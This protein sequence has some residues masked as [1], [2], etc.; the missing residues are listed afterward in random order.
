LVLWTGPLNTK[1]QR[2]GQLDE[3]RPRKKA[4]DPEWDDD[5]WDSD[6]ELTKERTQQHD[7]TLD[8]SDDES[9]S[10]MDTAKPTTEASSSEAIPE[11]KMKKPVTLTETR[12][13]RGVKT[14]DPKVKH[15]ISYWEADLGSS[16]STDV[17]QLVMESGERGKKRKYE[18]DATPIKNSVS[19]TSGYPCGPHITTKTWVTMPMHGHGNGRLWK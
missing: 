12:E 13:Q 1:G 3:V 6:V 19:K 15:T 14:S 5:S 18:E 8:G 16:E 9:V 11:R 10:S 7:Q 4:V 17:I 2:K